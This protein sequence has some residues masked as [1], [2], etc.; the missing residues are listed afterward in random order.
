[1]RSLC[2][3]GLITG[4]EDAANE[5]GTRARCANDASGSPTQRSLT[6]PAPARSVMYSLGA[7]LR[8]QG[9]TACRSFLGRL[10][11]PGWFLRRPAP[12]C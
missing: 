12:G 5:H 3:N 11:R 4:Y 1:M 7:P 10:R 6:K 2:V 9:K 8:N